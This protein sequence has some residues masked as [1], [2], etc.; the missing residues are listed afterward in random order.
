MKRVVS[1]KANDDF[2]LDVVF[3]D[4]AVRRFDAKPYLE[5]GIFRRLRNVEYFKNVHIAY[6]TIAWDDELDI[7][8]ETFTLKASL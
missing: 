4:G 6:G 1:A 5:K 7:A 3:S 8:P 2:T